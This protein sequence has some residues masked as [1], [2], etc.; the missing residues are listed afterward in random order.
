[1]HRS[2]TEALNAPLTRTRHWARASACS[3]LG[4]MNQP[5]VGFIG[6]GV[7]GASMAGHL[8]GAGHPVYV[9]NRSRA[10]AEALLARG[11]IWCDAP[12]AVA[13]QASLVIS[14][15]GTPDDVRSVYLGGGGL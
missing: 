5:A 1:M 14:M 7:M 2:R 6:T 9:Y 13:Q 11:A 15:V 12:A 3:T 8:L 4:R 10:K